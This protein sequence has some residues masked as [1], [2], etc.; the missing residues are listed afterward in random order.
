MGAE[1]VERWDQVSGARGHTTPLP[2]APPGWALPAPVCR[3]K[4]TWAGVSQLALL[5]L[6]LLEGSV[7][8]AP[9]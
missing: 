4:G 3:Q 7:G 8:R 5:G 1:S 6:K 2:P 9:I